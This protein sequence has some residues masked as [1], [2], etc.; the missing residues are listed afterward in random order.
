[1]SYAGKKPVVKVGD[2][3][4]ADN[5]RWTFSG[6]VAKSFDSHVERSVPLYK[7][8]H[9]LVCDVSDFLLEDGSVCYD[10]GCSTG[11]LIEALAEHNKNKD[12][13]F[14]GYDVEDAMVEKAR[15]RCKR[16][17]NVQI[18]K[19]DI[20]EVDLDT[21]D[22]IVSYLTIQFIRPKNRQI[23]M[24]RIYNSLNW[25][26]GFFLFEKVRGA[27]ARFQD[28][29]MQLYNEYKLSQGFE[30]EEIFAKSRSLK[31]VME[32]FSS[33]GNIDLLKRAGFQDITTLFKYIC[34]EGF[35]TIK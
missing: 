28:L 11:G 14:I 32:P 25:G 24:N 21:S 30:P 9:R 15:E 16:F 20:M 6:D 12:V 18:E 10:L 27:D 1:M 35:F 13:K 33:Q 17:P 26:G 22:F 5:A 7:E 31:G 34:F 4:Q 3:I 23:L 8:G 2:N 29:A 19:A